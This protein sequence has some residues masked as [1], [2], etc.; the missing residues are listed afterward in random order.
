MEAGDSAGGVDDLEDGDRDLARLDVGDDVLATFAGL[1]TPSSTATS[2]TGNSTVSFLA[3]N[4]TDLLR[5]GAGGGGIVVGNIA[6]GGVPLIFGTFGIGPVTYDLPSFVDATLGVAVAIG[7]MSTFGGGAL[8]VGAGVAKPFFTM[9]SSGGAGGVFVG[10]PSPLVMEVAFNREAR[11]S[12]TLLVVL[13]TP[14][15]NTG[16]GWRL[17]NKS[18][19]SRSLRRGALSKG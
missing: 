10:T 7:P 18:W 13:E 4:P 15:K 11:S 8:R 1:S 14:G 9:A 6:A 17:F 19:R 3:E 12:V 2:A 5:L 16:F